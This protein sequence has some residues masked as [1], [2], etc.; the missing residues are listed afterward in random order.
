[1]TTV[2]SGLARS[3]LL[4]IEPICPTMT[5]ALLGH[6]DVRGA[7]IVAPISATFTCM[8]ACEEYARLIL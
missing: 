8:L 1:M 6:L 4:K 7:G 5:G 3:S 2:S